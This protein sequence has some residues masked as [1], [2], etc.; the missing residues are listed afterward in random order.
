[1]FIKYDFIKEG[2][3]LI[4]ELVMP[5][6]LSIGIKILKKMGWK[7]GQGIGE[8]TDVAYIPETVKEKKVYR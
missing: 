8:K 7:P 6:K 3:A 5:A 1:V 4:D 2:Q